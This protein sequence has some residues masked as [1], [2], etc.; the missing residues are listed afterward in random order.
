VDLKKNF[1]TRGDAMPS[2]AFEVHLYI[3]FLFEIVLA[4]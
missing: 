2:A 1:S 4:I 3:M